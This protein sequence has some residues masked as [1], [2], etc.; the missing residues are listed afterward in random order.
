MAQASKP[1]API[2][3]RLQPLGSEARSPH[4]EVTHSLTQPRA[5]PSNPGPSLNPK[6]IRPLPPLTWGLPATSVAR[7]PADAVG[8]AHIIAVVALEP[9]VV[10]TGPSF[11]AI[12][13]EL[14]GAHLAAAAAVRDRADPWGAGRRP[15]RTLTNHWA[16]S[17]HL[18]E[19]TNS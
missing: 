18:Q 5:K 10:V 1:Q 14:G 16:A 19:G 3:E 15:R 11:V 8:T 7:T 4:P 12:L 2:K 6:A 13:V 17:S 9:F